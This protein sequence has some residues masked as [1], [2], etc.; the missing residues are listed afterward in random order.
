MSVGP[1]RFQILAR[2]EETAGPHSSGA[3]KL[4]AWGEAAAVGLLSPPQPFALGQ[5]K[6]FTGPLL[7]DCLH[8]AHSRRQEIP[9]VSPGLASRACRPLSRRTEAERE[10]TPGQHHGLHTREF[11]PRRSAVPV[12][13]SRPAGSV[14]A[15]ALELGSLGRLQ[16]HI[17]PGRLRPDLHTQPELQDGERT[18]ITVEARRLT[19][20]FCTRSA[21]RWGRLSCPARLPDSA[22]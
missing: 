22:F 11:F 13:G 20:A 14:D 12:H 17:T 3:W 15:L 19:S 6:S 16:H 21:V 2:L 18:M 4:P 9:F 7:T 5:P 1:P 8:C 10:P